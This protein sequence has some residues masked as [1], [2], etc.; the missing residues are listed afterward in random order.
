MTI[1]EALVR[2]GAG[3]VSL[4]L[5]YVAWFVYEDEE[6]TLQSKIEDWWLQFD[7]LRERMLTRQNAFVSVV[8]ARAREPLDRLLGD[9][10]ISEGTIAVSWCLSVGSIFGFSELALL[11]TFRAHIYPNIHTLLVGEGLVGVICLLAGIAPAIA[12]RYIWIPKVVWRVGLMV[13]CVYLVA[14]DALMF[15]NPRFT[16]GF[17]FV[18]VLLGLGAVGA[19]LGATALTLFTMRLARKSVALAEQ[20]HSEWRAVPYLLLALTPCV[21]I[22]AVSFAL[23]FALRG[24]HHTPVPQM[25][26]GMVGI[27][28]I[29]LVSLGSGLAVGYVALM[30]GTATLMTLHRVAWPMMS[31][32][33]YNLPRHRI[34]ESK[35]SLNA[36][37]SS[38]F[39]VALGGGYLKEILAYLAKL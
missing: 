7:D 16:V 33:L 21:A 29:G 14:F 5:F 15:M 24:G 35:K 19:F 8:A 20:A 1:V 26:F 31:R 34:L 17:K 10:R 28:M 13:L 25:D 11:G 4:P 39:A 22:V 9:G 30:L 2:V 6:K 12:P 36:A 38:L 23:A 3:L 37:A 32:I 18:A 27:S